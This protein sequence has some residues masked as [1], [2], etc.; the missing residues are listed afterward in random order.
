L[1]NK[2]W[3]KTQYLPVSCNWD[4]EP[5]FTAY[6]ID[7]IGNSPRTNTVDFEHDF[8][9][10]ICCLKLFV[11]ISIANFWYGCHSWTDKLE[12]TCRATEHCW[13]WKVASFCNP[14]TNLNKFSVKTVITEKPLGIVCIQSSDLNLSI[15]SMVI[16]VS[17]MFCSFYN[18]PDLPMCLW[19]GSHSPSLLWYF[20]YVYFSICLGFFLY[21]RLSVVSGILVSSLYAVLR[22]ILNVVTRNVCSLWRELWLMTLVVLLIHV[23][24]Y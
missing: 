3:C 1:C 4:T 19:K 16:A 14:S 6:H 23:S 24:T 8:C 18:F 15:A 13:L 21:N 12:E 5:C 2:R 20:K 9:F 17:K 7:W 11:C 10:F 22:F